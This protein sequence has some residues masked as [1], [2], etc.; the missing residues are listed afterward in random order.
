MRLDST[1]PA[2]DRLTE[3]STGIRF[4]YALV[5]LLFLVSGLLKA[6]HFAGLVAKLAAMGLPMAPLLSVL[7]T[8]VEVGCGGALILGWKTRWAAAVLA[9]FV[10]PA[11]FLFHAFWAADASSYSNQ[12]NHF[13]K[14][15]GLF[16]ALLAMAWTPSS[17]VAGADGRATQYPRLEKD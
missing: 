17:G 8:C 16:G 9:M 13:L 5:G 10:V 15:V 6:T 2:L 3:S 1:S 11:T 7:V 12:L 4:G 14:N